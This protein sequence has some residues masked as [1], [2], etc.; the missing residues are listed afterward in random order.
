[1]LFTRFQCRFKS[2]TP[3]LVFTA[4]VAFSA[5]LKE[6]MPFSSGPRGPFMAKL[7]GNGETRGAIFT[8]VFLIIIT[9]QGVIPG[10]NY[11][12][13]AL[14]FSKGCQIPKKKK[15]ITK[16]VLQRLTGKPLIC[17]SLGNQCFLQLERGS[18]LS[19]CWE[20]TFEILRVIISVKQKWREGKGH[21][22]GNLL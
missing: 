3:T 22:L 4:Q 13:A 10:I 7:C 6:Q 9:P 19:D 16:L 1:M 15:K 5:S 18:N 20:R 2:T 14:S 8:I 12:V 11:F 17:F 21:I